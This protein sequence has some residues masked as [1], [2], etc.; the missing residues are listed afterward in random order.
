MSL[1]LEKLGT[2]VVVDGTNGNILTYRNIKQPLSENYTL[3]NRRRQVKYLLSH[4]RHIAQRMAAPNDF[5]DSKLGK[6][7][8]RLVVKKLL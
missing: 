8:D 6:Y 2:I 7:I 1:G 4:Q 5:G 3:L